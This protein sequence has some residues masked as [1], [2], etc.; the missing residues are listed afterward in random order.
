MAG[1]RCSELGRGHVAV[2]MAA[3]DATAKS[4]E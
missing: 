4:E 1:I 3:G 2:P